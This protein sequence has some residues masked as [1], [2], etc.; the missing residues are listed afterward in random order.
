MIHPCTKRT[1]SESRGF[2]GSNLRL[3]V[4]DSQGETVLGHCSGS[5]KLGVA[6]AHNTGGSLHWVALPQFLTFLTI[7]HQC[8]TVT[9]RALLFQILRLLLGRSYIGSGI[10]PDQ[11]VWAGLVWSGENKRT[12]R[13]VPSYTGAS[14]RSGR[15]GR[16]G[17]GLTRTKQVCFPPD[18]TS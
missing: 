6:P 15:S 18:Q 5:L 7:Q 4:T 16:V 13:R 17:T 9:N 12:P 11:T 2:G 10:S 1:R 8:M 14:Y 3:K